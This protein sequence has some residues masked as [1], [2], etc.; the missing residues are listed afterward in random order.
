MDTILEIWQSIVGEAP[1]YFTIG[2]SNSIQWNYGE[3]L[4]YAFVCIATIFVIALVFKLLF[5]MFTLIFGGRN[6]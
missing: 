2:S 6:K 1:S 3:L 5:T 4:E